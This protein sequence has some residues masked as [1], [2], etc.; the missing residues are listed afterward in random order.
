MANLTSPTITSYVHVV[1]NPFEV[2]E[3]ETTVVSD[4]QAEHCLF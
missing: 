2:E 4:V 1:L 3:E